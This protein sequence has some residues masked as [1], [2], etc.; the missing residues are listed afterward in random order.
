MTG[1]LSGKVRAI[2]HVAMSA[3]MLGPGQRLPKG[4]GTALDLKFP[5]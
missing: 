4:V 1:L 2:R 3:A 5:V